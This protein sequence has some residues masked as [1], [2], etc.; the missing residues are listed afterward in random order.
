M[1]GIMTSKLVTKISNTGT[2]YWDICPPEK[3]NGANAS[4]FMTFRAFEEP[5]PL[6]KKLPL[7]FKAAKASAK[8][9]RSSPYDKAEVFLM[10]GKELAILGKRTQ[11]KNAFALSFKAAKRIGDD[12][13]RSEVF[14]SIARRQA[15]FDFA[16]EAKK[17]VEKIPA[18][19]IRKRARVLVEEITAVNQVLKQASA[20]PE[21]YGDTSMS[22][23]F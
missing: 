10:L 1:S 9:T 18:G 6:A 8:K 12:A 4:C 15:R 23:C 3:S 2:R 20:R 21:G 5:H 16:D 22:I 17:T 11:A 14:A 7:I 19:K 13:D